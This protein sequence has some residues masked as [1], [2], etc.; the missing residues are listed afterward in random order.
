MFKAI[1]PATAKNQSA[2]RNTVPA[3][4]SMYNVVYNA[5]VLNA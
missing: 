5:P 3:S 4:V 1:K 2:T